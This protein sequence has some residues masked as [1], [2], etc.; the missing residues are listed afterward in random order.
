MND[1]SRETP[2]DEAERSPSLSSPE[3]RID[4]LRS[5]R[6]DAGSRYEVRGE[7]GHGGMGT[8]YEIWDTDLRRPL[9]MKLLRGVADAPVGSS[10]SS[11]S[12]VRF[13]EEAQITAQLDHPGIVPVHELG[14]D[15]DGRVYFT[16]GRV[17]G[18]TLKQVVQDMHSGSAEWTLT[19]AVGV[20][21]KVCETMAFAHAKGAV[22]RD[23]KPTDVMIGRYGAVYVMD[24]GLACLKGKEELAHD[25]R[26]RQTSEVSLTGI[27]T[28]RKPD[29]ES[30]V[31]SPLLTMD[32]AVIGTP[33]YMSPEQARG[34]IEHVG[35]LSD[36]YSV[37]A[38]LYQVLTGRTP[39]VAPGM[40]V[41]AHM[42][43]ALVI[44][45][46]PEPVEQFAR[47]PA[48][49][50]AI[51]DK[52][53]A[54]DAADR[55]PS[56]TELADDLAAYLEGRVVRA[57]ETGAWAE[58]KKWVKRNRGLAVS[59]GAALL[60][61]ALGLALW[62]W[63]RERHADERFLAAD[64]Y[65]SAYYAESAGELWPAAPRVAPAM[66]AWIADVEAL[67]ARRERHA[68]R[69]AAL[70]A[71]DPS[72]PEAAAEAALLEQLDRLASDDPETSVLADVRARLAFAE[73]VRART[74]DDLADEWGAARAAIA[75]HPDYG[76]LALEPQLGLVPLGPDPSSGLW[77]FAHVASGVVPERGADG[78]LALDADSAIVL[79][80]IPG[81]EFDM[82]AV[83]G[84]AG[85]N[86]DMSAHYYEG[87]IHTVALEPYFLAKH[88]M[89]QAQWHRA[90]HA[91]PSQYSPG[92]PVE[93]WLTTGREWLHPVESVNW[94]ECERVLAQ[95][96]LVLPTEAQ[97]ER[98][99]RAGTGTRYDGGHDRE[100]LIGAAN[101]ADA[102]AVAIGAQ[103]PETDEWPEF[104][105][106]FPSHAPVD[107]LRPNRWGLHHVHGN[108]LEWCADW[109]VQYSLGDARE[110][111]GLRVASSSEVEG[112]FKVAR[113][114]SH[115]HAASEARVSY[116]YYENPKNLYYFIGVRPARALDR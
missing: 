71:E 108:V 16:M 107:A 44:T 24:W 38:M 94:Y 88:E 73:G 33:A 14:V 97:W 89:T 18:R 1:P 106:G 80:L 90:T 72:S 67:L 49:L 63:T 66:R 10:H 11:P 109:F 114:G 112:S 57:Y 55:Y 22:H 103:W 93:E 3:A 23:L 37:G 42:L 62:V 70:R 39:Y 34:E 74:I 111:D 101:L 15:A 45:G 77:E 20:I 7:L 29:A 100:V 102:S 75:E 36:V 79:V 86:R 99:A 115:R 116:R 105:D 27:R 104:D 13:L 98:A 95:L 91:V 31:E 6:P 8:V 53:M 5:Q 83:T 58:A 26:L 19:R 68:E 25:I 96:S 61:T 60:A 40:R 64:V 84:L 32:G 85:A 51:C 78:A 2:P 41:S 81:G 43:L 46:P 69:L 48:E 87:P 9:A 82:G 17:K 113:G 35:P 65:R 56:M 47:V 52:A 54:R 76:G 12:L 92:S 4:K 110:G 30:D 59:A 50:V 28:D 21:H